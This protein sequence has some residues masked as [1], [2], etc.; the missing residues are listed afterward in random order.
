MI[1][2]VT[3]SS[4][5][6]ML[7]KSTWKA[8]GLEK[9]CTGNAKGAEQ[10]KHAAQHG[11]YSKY[12]FSA[13]PHQLTLPYA[14]ATLALRTGWQT[15]LWNKEEQENNVSCCHSP[16]DAMAVKKHTEM[17]LCPAV[18][19]GMVQ[20]H[21]TSARLLQQSEHTPIMEDGDRFGGVKTHV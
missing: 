16:G 10:D 6:A 5:L 14:L 11:S 17:P 9:Q 7:I 2:E 1:L 8:S 12:F 4:S 20:N 21:H 3:Q 19:V 18:H 15:V 13:K